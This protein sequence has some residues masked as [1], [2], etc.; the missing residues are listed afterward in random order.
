MA[1]RML[2]NELWSK[3]KGILRQHRIYDKPFLRDMVE[4]MLY[5]MRV[6]C[7]WRDLP[8]E[9]GCWN[10]IFQKFNR[11]SAKN[12]LMMIFKML[13][14]EPDLEWEFIDG[15]IVKAH[16]HSAG[17]ASNEEQG[18]GKSVAGNTTKIHM[19]VDGFGL[20]IEFE[21]TGG[22]VHDCKI[23][24]ELIN[25]LPV[26]DYVIAD[27]GYD[28]EELR[29]IVRNKSSISIIPRKSNSTVGN[30][31]VDWG[32]YKHRHLVE[33]IFARLK[34]FRSIA[35]RYDKLKRNFSSMLALACSYLWLPM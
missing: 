6:G 9:F 4:G 15:S 16:Q 13:V 28:S 10:S 12:K 3:L 29:E 31:D 18:I 5:R 22:E 33:N 21:I 25:K 32:L 26:S 2:T 30:F 34:H 14:D 20:P 17:A 7:P 24:R 35:T 19:A 27:K 1:R 11:W 23:A 8:E